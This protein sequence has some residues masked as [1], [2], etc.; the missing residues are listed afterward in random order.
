M[1]SIQRQSGA[2]HIQLETVEA[3]CQIG[4]IVRSLPI[5]ETEVAHQT[6]ATAVALQ[7]GALWRLPEAQRTAPFIAMVYL[8]LFAATW[9]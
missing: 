8:P 5:G 3:I 1:V 2:D 9:A 4:V 6:G 7:T